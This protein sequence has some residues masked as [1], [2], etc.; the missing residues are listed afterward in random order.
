MKILRKIVAFISFL[1]L[2]GCDNNRSVSEPMNTGELRLEDKEQAQ[3][4]NTSD[5]QPKPENQIERKF[6]KNG[7]IEFETE[8]LNKTREEIFKAIKKYHGYISSENEYKIADE[9]SSNII[10]RVPADD[11][12]KLIEEITIGVKR[13][14]RK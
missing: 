12:D 9:I 11:F 3:N 10:R 13:F 14:D 5:F 7:Q 1:A 4:L 6:I 8:D 2:M